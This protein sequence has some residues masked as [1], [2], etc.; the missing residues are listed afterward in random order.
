MNDKTLQL[1]VSVADSGSFSRAEERSFISKQ[2]IRKQ[3]D[4]LE[5]ELGM[6]LF[7]RSSQGVRLTAPG[8]QFYTGAKDLLLRQERLIAECRRLAGGEDC[9]R[10]STVEHQAL[11]GEVLETYALRYPEIRIRRVIHPNHSGEFRVANDLMDVA[12]TFSNPHLL[13]SLKSAPLAYTPLV[14]LPF[15]AAVPPEHPLAAQ[16]EV[17]LEELSA[18]PCVSFGP[19]LPQRLTEAL[20]EAYAACPEQLQLRRDVDNQVPAVFECMEEGSVF[21]TASWF[22]RQIPGLALRPLRGGWT[23][24]F[25]VLYRT[26]VSTPVRR[27]VELG[28]DLFRRRPL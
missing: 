22:I 17:S 14:E 26:P 3:M 15:L 1:F 11:L 16:E 12:E 4:A 10:I 8:Q 19:M 13:H 5:D 23:Q 7:E 6:A 9:L 27:F 25:G 18:Y 28:Q 24:E 2:A 20:R 21:L